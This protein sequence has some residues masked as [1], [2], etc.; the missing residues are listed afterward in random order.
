MIES[1]DNPQFILK[2]L[3]IWV[4]SQLLEKSV[5]TLMCPNKTHLKNSRLL[6]NTLSFIYC[7]KIE[8]FQGFRVLNFK[9]FLLF[10]DIGN[11]RGFR[12][13]DFGPY[14]EIQNQ[15]NSEIFSRLVNFKGLFY[16]RK[17]KI[18]KVYEFSILAFILKSKTRKT[19][20]FFQ[21]L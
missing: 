1:Q 11:F 18:S 16:L 9:K 13:F 19:R 21:G 15:E 7:N 5:Y 4:F 20:K 12:L 17:K 2:I 3:G 10:E 8:K 6:K 14:T